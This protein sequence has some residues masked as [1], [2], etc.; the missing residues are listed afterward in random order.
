MCLHYVQYFIAKEGVTGL[1]LARTGFLGKC[2]QEMCEEEWGCQ[3][4]GGG[5]N[6]QFFFRLRIQTVVSP[7]GAGRHVASA[8]LHH[9]N[10]TNVTTPF[11]P[12]ITFT[13]F[14][15]GPFPDNR[16]LPKPNL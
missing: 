11:L 13:H 12:G 4:K 7:T 1:I 3:A 9:H 15:Q 8:A 14:S 6:V 16:A 2:L 10:S 5:V